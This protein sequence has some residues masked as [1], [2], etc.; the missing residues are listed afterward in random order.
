M[1]IFIENFDYEIDKQDNDNIKNTSILYNLVRMEA[2]SK[3]IDASSFSKGIYYIIEN[4][5]N[6]YQI[7][8]A[9]I[10][11]H[12]VYFCSKCENVENEKIINIDYLREKNKLKKQQDI[13]EL[14]QLKNLVI[15]LLEKDINEQDIIS[16]VNEG[17]EEYK[18]KQLI[19]IH[20]D[21]D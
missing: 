9:T 11:H 18:K 20:F 14:K 13:E 2:K 3:S 21:T 17:V 8:L 15:K 5:G 1:P 12:F 6:N 10:N 19:K 7:G 4:M 16:S